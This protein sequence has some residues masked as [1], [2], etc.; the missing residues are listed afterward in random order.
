MQEAFGVD[1]YDD[2]DG[3]DLSE[4]YDYDDD[5]DDDGYDGGDDSGMDESTDYLSLFDFD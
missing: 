5:Y 2:Y 4:G 1:S 3:E